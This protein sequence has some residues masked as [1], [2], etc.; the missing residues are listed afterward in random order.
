M[1]Q[2]RRYEVEFAII[3]PGLRIETRGHPRLNNDVFEIAAYCT[4]IVNDLVMID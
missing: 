4:L 1:A 3:I 2:K